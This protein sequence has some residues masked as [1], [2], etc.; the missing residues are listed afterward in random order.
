MV[1]QCGKRTGKG[2]YVQL[3]E[4][5]VGVAV[6]RLALALL[7]DIVLEDAGGLRIVAVEAIENHVD[8]LG[9]FRREVEGGAH[10]D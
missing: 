1:H 10:G 4:G 5:E 6:V 9:P 8:V 3:Q 2:V 7:H